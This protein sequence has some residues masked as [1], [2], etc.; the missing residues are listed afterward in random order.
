[1]R[2]R[3]CNN[4]MLAL[5]GISKLVELLV[6]HF[7]K[8]PYVTITASAQRTFALSLLLGATPLFYQRI[9]YTMTPYNEAQPSGPEELLSISHRPFLEHPRFGYGAFTFNRPVQL[10]LLEF[11]KGLHTDEVSALLCRKFR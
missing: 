1:M 4:E 9:L 2:L 3:T 8:H 5:N 11:R 6:A 10:T 7:A